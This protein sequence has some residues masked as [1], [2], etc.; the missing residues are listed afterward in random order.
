MIVIM[1]VIALYKLTCFLSISIKS[2]MLSFLLFKSAKSSLVFSRLS[3]LNFTKS[4][5]RPS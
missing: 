3:M 5:K 2:F 4:I 1:I